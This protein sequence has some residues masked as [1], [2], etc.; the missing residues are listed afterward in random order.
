[1]LE[2]KSCKPKLNERFAL[3]KSNWF[4]NQWVFVSTAGTNKQLR[5][6]C[7][8]G[9]DIGE[10]KCCRLKM[11]LFSFT[12]KRH[13]MEF[14]VLVVAPGGKLDLIA[15]AG[16]AKIFGNDRH[17]GVR[18]RFRK[19]WSWLTGIDE[20]KKKFC[21]R[22]L[23]Y[24]KTQ[25]S[26]E[27]VEAC[28]T[29]KWGKRMSCQGIG[30]TEKKRVIGRNEPGQMAPM[31]FK[32]PEPITLQASILD[33]ETILIRVGGAG[34]GDIVQVINGE[35]FEILV[36]FKA[37]ILGDV[38]LVATSP[39]LEFEPDN[40]VNGELHFK[41]GD[42]RTGSWMVKADVDCPSP[43]MIVIV[44]YMITKDDFNMWKIPTPSYLQVAPSEADIETGND[45]NMNTTLC[46][47][48]EDVCMTD[49]VIC[50][51]PEQIG[52]E[53]LCEK[54]PAAKGCG[55][56][57][58]VMP[59]DNR[60]K[61][62]DTIKLL[63]IIAMWTAAGIMVGTVLMRNFCGGDSKNM[64][65]LKEQMKE[66]NASIK[67]PKIPKDAVDAS[68]FLN[69]AGFDPDHVF[70]RRNPDPIVLAQAQMSLKKMLGAIK[71]K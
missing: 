20:T 5:V 18:L 17:H 10:K 36:Y 34:Q 37:K 63:A 69:L 71:S 13:E 24:G 46:Q 54:V 41:K 33:M 8:R 61:R 59:P 29:L 62:E 50:G 30:E 64:K 40:G 14:D 49:D 67:R 68:E 56:E 39:K 28:Y 32:V 22:P 6:K 7:S 25:V 26:F 55:A 66:L 31:D 11:P 53:M 1:L 19:G 27:I 70:N 38:T 15:V 43:T 45:M 65:R 52:K 23:K 35:W 4:K 16:R 57:L 12:R 9:A 44:N 60:K 3:E 48:P 47:L 2:C 21:Y 42:G 51:T 58:P